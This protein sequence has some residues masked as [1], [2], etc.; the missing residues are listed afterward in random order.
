[1]LGNAYSFSSPLFSEK[2]I[3]KEE[4]AK[5]RKQA[6]FS[7]LNDPKNES[8]LF[9]NDKVKLLK[10]EKDQHMKRLHE[11]LSQS[12]LNTQSSLFPWLSEELGPLTEKQQELVTTL[13]LIRIEEYIITYR[14]YPGRPAQDRTAIA[15]AF[16]T[17][18]LYSCNL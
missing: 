14:G 17:H 16:L 13:E 2:L 9:I 6:E 15:R 4:L 18:F 7:G 8:S 3:L 12:W 10:L 11:T 1:M 5:F